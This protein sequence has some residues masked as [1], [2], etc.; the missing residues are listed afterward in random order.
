PPLA[1]PGSAPSSSL[2][3]MPGVDRTMWAQ[4]RTAAVTAVCCAVEARKNRN[5]VRSRFG[6]G[7]VCGNDLIV[8]STGVKDVDLATASV[9]RRCSD[10][11]IPLKLRQTGTIASTS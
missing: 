10:Y 7:S 3:V 8:N 4:A 9:T 1:L 6:C 5:G 11:G 2:S